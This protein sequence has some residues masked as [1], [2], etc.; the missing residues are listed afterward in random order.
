MAAMWGVPAL[1]VVVASVAHAGPVRVGIAAAPGVIKAAAE[2]CAGNVEWLDPLPSALPSLVDH[3]AALARAE[4]SFELLDFDAVRE[5]L[6]DALADMRRSGRYDE[7]RIRAELLVARMAAMDVRD[8]E[9]REAIAALTIAH[10]FREPDAGRIPPDVVAEIGRLRAEWYS[11]EVRRIETVPQARSLRL[12]GMAVD[13][14]SPPAVPAPAF[15]LQLWA[16]DERLGW[17]GPFVV[18]V[19]LDLHA[20]Y[21]MIAAHFSPQPSYLWVSRGR[22]IDAL[23]G[24]L[25]WSEGDALPKLCALLFPE[26]GASA[27]DLG[28]VPSATPVPLAETGSDGASP[29]PGTGSSGSAGKSSWIRN[30]WFLGAVSAALVSGAGVGIWAATRPDRSRAGAIVVEW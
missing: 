8:D 7:Q 11:G 3:S 6:S 2:S 5:E 14:V 30:P 1:A 22:M 23:T 19:G 24:E 13:S 20:D 10:L 25:R 28:M 27:P 16:Q 9:R 26:A 15:G 4:R 17:L 21:A 29:V 12:G 18:G